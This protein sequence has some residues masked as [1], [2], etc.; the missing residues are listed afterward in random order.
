MT[1]PAGP[2]SPGGQALPARSPGGR[3]LPAWAPGLRIGLFGGSFNPPHEGHRLASLTAMRRLGLDRVWWIVT[4]G[5][6]LKR[7]DG[8]ADLD[9][10]IAAARRLADHPR[11]V[12]T[13]V[14]AGIGMRYTVDT[15]RHLRRRCP[16]VH[17]VWIMGADNL[18]QLPRW[19]RWRELVSLV[20]VAVV[21]RPG[22]TFRSLNGRAAAVLAPGRLRESEAKLLPTRRHPAF[23]YLHGPRSSASS[24]ALR[25][26]GRGLIPAGAPGS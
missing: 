6:P 10:R 4:P 22:S 16:G 17:F 25:D 24:T 20:P 1:P 5:N 21:D 14:E 3:A 23:V 8:L 9:T 18:L 15:I 12:A 11:I 26:A 7:H 2:R 19:R 13:G